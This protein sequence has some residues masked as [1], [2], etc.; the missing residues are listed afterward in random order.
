MYDRLGLLAPAWVD[1]VT[2]YRYYRAGSQVERGPARGRVC[3]SWTCRWPGSPRWS[4]RATVSWRP[5]WLGAYWADVEARLAGQRTLAEY[6]RGRL[7]GGVPRCTRKFA[8]E[9]VDVPEQVVI[10]ETRHTLAD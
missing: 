3:G 5:A 2:G 9:T 7:S 8:V 6:L 10:T 1:E 4:R